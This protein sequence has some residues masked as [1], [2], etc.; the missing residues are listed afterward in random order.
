MGGCGLGLGCAELPTPFG[1]LRRVVWAG[2]VWNSGE[3]AGWEVCFLTLRQHLEVL[4][5]SL[6]SEGSSVTEV[7]DDIHPANE[8]GFEP[9]SETTPECQVPSCSVGGFRC[10]EK[11]LV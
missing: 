3:R 9:S 6:C 1:Y 2:G 4:L 7:N 8:S 5:T 11:T 10:K